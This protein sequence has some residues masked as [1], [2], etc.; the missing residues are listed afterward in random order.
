MAATSAI[1]VVARWEA[2]W[3]W[4]A[5]AGA[6]L[7]FYAIW[8]PWALVNTRALVLFSPHANFPNISPSTL[9]GTSYAPGALSSALFNPVFLGWF[10]ALGLLIV[11]FLW[12]RRFRP[13]AAGLFA[14]WLVGV[15]LVLLV[16]AG[17]IMPLVAGGQALVALD[18]TTPRVGMLAALLGLVAGWATV[19]PLVRDALRQV[20]GQT[21]EQGITGALPRAPRRE[22]AEDA[23]SA[24][25]AHAGLIS[26]GAG[27]LTAGAVLWGISLLVLPWALGNCPASTQP[28]SSCAGLSAAT[29]MA[30]ASLPAAAWIDALVFQVGVPVLLVGG[31]L[32][33]L[34]AAWRLSVNRRL[35]GWL[36]VWL[37]LASGA[38]AL[39]MA[40]QAEVLAGTIPV[41]LTR[42][43]PY[44]GNVLG[45]VGLAC[46]WL[47]LVPLIVAVVTRRRGEPTAA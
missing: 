22:V 1:S 30:V 37:A 17:V 45:E 14:L 19:V 26:G 42:P 44:S 11:P 15:T 4:L 47:A 13:L 33:A 41:G 31:A 35:C 40:G 3:R 29:A 6:A 16:A 21:H 9:T 43:T 46:G 38:L 32:L 34:A 39:G 20:R 7:G 28:G 8:A 10:S 24:V 12:S 25:R 2:R 23:P 18:G 36:A 27:T 5:L